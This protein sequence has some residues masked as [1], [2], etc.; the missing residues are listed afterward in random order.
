MSSL[1]SEALP[2]NF[3]LKNT[4]SVLREAIF[5]GPISMTTG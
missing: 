5:S 4:I 3:N 1:T 2:A